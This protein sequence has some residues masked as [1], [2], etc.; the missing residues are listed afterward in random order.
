MRQDYLSQRVVRYVGVGFIHDY[1][2]IAVAEE[3]IDYVDAIP[4]KQ[5]CDVRCNSRSV[6]A[7]EGKYSESLATFG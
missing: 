4:V 6:L 7:L 5:L 1:C 3:G 2:D